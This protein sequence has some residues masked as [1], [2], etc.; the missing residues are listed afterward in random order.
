MPKAS[1]TAGTPSGSMAS[2]SATVR[3]RPRSRTSAKAMIVP[4]GTAIAIVVAANCSEF[5]SASVSDTKNSCRFS[6]VCS[7]S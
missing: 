7:A 4:S 2:A 5:P 1:V 3:L 6:F